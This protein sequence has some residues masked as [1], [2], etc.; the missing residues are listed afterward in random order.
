MPRWENQSAFLMAGKEAGQWK[1]RG[2]TVAPR[3]FPWLSLGPAGV[4]CTPVSA[5]ATSSNSE[6]Q[7]EPA[8]ERGR[9]GWGG[10]RDAPR[11]VRIKCSPRTTP[12]SHSWHVSPLLTALPGW[13]NYCY[14]KTI[15]M[16]LYCL[17][18]IN[19]PGPILPSAASPVDLGTAFQA[20]HLHFHRQ[21]RSLVW[22][23]PS[24]WHNLWW[25]CI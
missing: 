15:S 20:L 12:S 17:V 8:G 9:N 3:H 14:T 7:R 11:V 21:E 6:H 25:C 23:T 19:C 2:I 18:E 16:P 24:N 10:G 1:K 5:E 22:N 4:S 13:E